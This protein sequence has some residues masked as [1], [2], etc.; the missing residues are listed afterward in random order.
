MSGEVG[1]SS[2]SIFLLGVFCFQV[3]VVEEILMNQILKFQTQVILDYNQLT[4]ISC[5]TAAGALL[6]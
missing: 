5:D 2:C 3:A 4:H 6:N 1:G